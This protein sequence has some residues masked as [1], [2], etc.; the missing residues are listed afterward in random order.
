[1]FA[2]VVKKYS[3]REGKNFINQNVFHEKYSKLT[4][5]YFMI[6]INPSQQYTDDTSNTTMRGLCY[7]NLQVYVLQA[8]KMS[9]L[10]K[11]T[12]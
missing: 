11:I 5:D 3:S 1:M 2:E 8:N 7:V 6:R 4:C 9:K 10:I 12:M